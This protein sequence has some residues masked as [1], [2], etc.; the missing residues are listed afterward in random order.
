MASTDTDTDEIVALRQRELTDQLVE[1]IVAIRRSSIV[2]A[3]AVLAGSGLF[4]ASLATFSLAVF[5][6]L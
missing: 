5:L 2:K 6:V 3:A 4:V 1:E